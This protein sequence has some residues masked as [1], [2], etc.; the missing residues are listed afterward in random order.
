MVYPEPDRYVVQLGAKVGYTIDGKV[1]E[2]F[3]AFL[4]IG[5]GATPEQARTDAVLLLMRD[6]KGLVV[7]TIDLEP[8]EGGHTGD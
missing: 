7:A 4:D 2:D 5:V 3:E 1:K 8:P 6:L